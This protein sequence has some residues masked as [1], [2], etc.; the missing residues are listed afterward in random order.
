MESKMFTSGTAPSVIKMYSGIE[1]F[2]SRSVWSLTADLVVLKVAI[3]ILT[4]KGQQR[5]IKCIYATFQFN[6]QLVIIAIQSFGLFDELKGKILEDPPVPDLIGSG[7][8]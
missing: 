2:R 7:D 6:I 1:V 4:G 3:K 8:G 5:F